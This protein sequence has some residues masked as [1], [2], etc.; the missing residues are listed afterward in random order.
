MGNAEVKSFASGAEDNTHY[1]SQFMNLEVLSHGQFL[2][3]RWV[4]F[5][6][7]KN[8][9]YQN[10]FDW[11]NVQKV[12]HPE[13]I[14]ENIRLQE[15]K[16]SLLVGRLPPMISPDLLNPSFF[17]DVQL[18]FSPSDVVDFK[19]LQNKKFLILYKFFYTLQKLRKQDQNPISSIQSTF[20]GG[21]P[22]AAEVG[23]RSGVHLLISLLREAAK[24]NQQLSDDTLNFLLELFIDVK[25]LSLWGTQQIDI[26]LDKSLHTVADYLEELISSEKTS[27][28][29]KRKALKVLFSLGLLRGSLPNLLSVV[30]LL[31]KYNLDVDLTRELKLLQLEKPNTQ[32]NFEKKLKAY[33]KIFFT[34][35]AGDAQAEKSPYVSMT[36]D[37]KYIYLH[38]ELE[39]LM[40]IGTGFGY[41]MF[42]KVYKHLK[43]YRTKEKGT[44]AFVLGKLYYRSGRIAPAPLIELDP[45][46]LEET[47]IPVHYDTLAPNSIFGELTNPEIEFPIQ[48]NS[49]Q[50][51]RG[52]LD[53]K[54]PEQKKLPSAKSVGAG[55][56]NANA[57]QNR[58]AAQQKRD[59]RLMRPAQRSPMFTDGRYI[60]IVSQWTVDSRAGRSGGGDSDDEDEGENVETKQARY[61][62]DI[63]DPVLDFEHVRAVELFDPNLIESKESNKT[64]QK[65]ALTAKALDQAIFTTNGSEL[66]VG[67]P[68]GTDDS[69][70][71]RYKFFSLTDGKLR[72][73]NP[74]KDA[75]HFYNVCYDSYNNVVFSLNDNKKTFDTISCLNNASVAEPVSF[76]EE[77]DLF[78]PFENRQIIELASE[79]VGLADQSD[80]MHKKEKE[81]KKKEEMQL[82]MSVGF[83]DDTSNYKANDI[84]F[85]NAEN[86]VN[87]STATQLF[88]LANIA[89]LA[90][91]YANLNQQGT[92]DVAN[93]IRKPY[94]V[95]LIGK[96]FRLLEEFIETYSHNF[97]EASE[98]QITDEFMFDQCS[99][100]CTLRI[101]KYNLAALENYSESLKNIGLKVLNDDFPVKLQKFIWRIFEMKPSENPDYDDIRK[102]LYKEALGIL[103]YALSIIYPD[104]SSVLSL[105]KTHLK[106]LSN[107]LNRDI[108]N[109]ILF[110]LKSKDHIVKL[111]AQILESPEY[112]SLFIKE[113]KDLVGQ[114][115]SW[116]VSQFCQYLKSCQEWE[117]LPTYESTELITTSMSFAI[118]FQKEI[119]FQLGVKIQDKSLEHTAIH[120]SSS[121]LTEVLCKNGILINFE[122][123][124][125]LSRLGQKI[126]DYFE[127]VEKSGKL[128]EEDSEKKIPTALLKYK[129]KLK[130]KKNKDELILEAYMDTWE[131]ICNVYVEKVY[132]SQILTYQL[133]ALSLLSSN[134]L[135]ASKT[136]KSISGFLT[137]LN[138]L[139]DT[140]KKYDQ[141][142]KEALATST[143]ERQLVFES[144]HPPPKDSSKKEKV[145]IPGAK[146]LKVVFDSQCELR[147]HHDWLQFFKDEQCRQLITQRMDRAGTWPKTELIIKGDFFWYNFQKNNF[148]DSQNWGY[149][150]TVSAS[151]KE[152]LEGD[153]L[154][155]LHR[156]T[157]WLAG[158]C[159]GQLING[160]A[161]QQAMLQ[162]EEQKYNSLLNS[163]LFSGG[164]EKC[165]FSGGKEGVWAQ[166]GDVINEFQAGH[167]SEYL[168]GEIS[169]AEKAEEE[170]LKDIIYAGRDEQ[171]DKTIEFIQKLFSKEA[172]WAN[173]GGENGSKCVRAAYAVIIKHSGLTNDLKE[174]MIEVE[175]GIDEKSKISPN[176]KNL[177]KKWGAASRMRSWLV[178]R[179][180]D[181]DDREEK[182]K[183]MAQAT[184]KQTAKTAMPKK[185]TFT[186]RKAARGRKA[187]EKSKEAQKEEA[188][189]EVVQM[190]E[191]KDEDPITQGGMQ[192]RDTEEIIQRMIDQIVKKAEFLC[193]LIPSK[194]WSGDR[195]EKREKQLLFRT[196]SKKDEEVNKEEEW[197]RRLTQ[198]KS[199]RQAKQVY[200][201]LEDESQEIHASLNTSVILCLQ[202]AVSIKRLRKQVESAYL[203]AI[204]RTIGL[205]ALTSILT[206]VK[207]SLFKQ[208]VVGWLCT[209]LRGTENK[210]YHFTDNLQGCG[211]YLESTVN[212]AFKN[213][214]IAIIKSMSKSDQPEEVNCMLEALKWKYHGDDHVFL[215]EID[216]FGILRGQEDKQLLR[217]AWGQSTDPKF[218]GRVEAKLV[219]NL[220]TLFETVLILCV[221]KL[222]WTAADQ[223]P[224]PK[225]DKLPSL[226][227]HVSAIDEYSVEI[228]IKQAF[229]VLFAELEEADNN[230]AKY[231]GINWRIYNRVKAVSEYQQAKAE[232]RSKQT[233]KKKSG[234]AR[235]SRRARRYND[236]EDDDY[237]D[238]GYEEDYGGMG[239]LPPASQNT[240]AEPKKKQKET[241]SDEELD[242]EEEQ[243][244]KEMQEEEKSGIEPEEESKTG[245]KSGKKEEESKEKDKPS[246]EQ[247]DDDE[248]RAARKQR[249]RLLNHLIENEK[250]ILKEMQQRLY[251]PDF[252]YRLLALIYKCVTMGSDNVSV[253]IGNPKY[254]ATLFSLIKHSPSS[255]QILITKT[256]QALFQT[257]PHELFID[258]IADLQKKGETEDGYISLKEKE[259][260]SSKV[261]K[262]FLNLLIDV[263][264]K[265]YVHAHESQ[266]SFSVSCETTGLI[267][268]L[269][270][271]PN[272]GRYVESW[273]TESIKSS[274]PLLKQ[275]AFAILGGD[276]NGLRIGGKIAIS[277][278]NRDEI[279]ADNILLK[280]DLPSNPDYAT[281]VGF[282]VEYAE[283]INEE[284]AKK[285]EKAKPA[286]KEK[287]KIRMDIGSAYSNLNPL[288]LIHSTISKEIP[289]FST[290]ELAT[291][292]R[293]NCVSKDTAPFEPESYE[294]NKNAS[295]LMPVYKWATGEDIPKD[296]NNL[297]LRTLA[298]KSLDAFSKSQENT[299]LLTSQHQ[300]LVASILNLATQSVVSS[301]LMNLELTEEKLFR[302]LQQSC[303]KGVTL[304]ELPPL[305]VTMKNKEIEILL[306]KDLSAARF[307][308]QAGFNIQSIKKYHEM[309]QIENP[310]EFIKRKD[311]AEYLADKAVLLDGQYVQKYPEIILNAQM[312]I[313][314]N[315]DLQKFAD[316]YDQVFSQSTKKNEE[317]KQQEEDRIMFSKEEALPTK[318][319]IKLPKCIVLVSDR[320]FYALNK[321]FIQ[322]KNK[323]FKEV[324]ENKDLLTELVEYGF[325]KDV[326]EKYLQENP[327]SAFDIVVNDIVKIIEQE[328]V[329]K[330]GQKKG[331][332]GPQGGSGRGVQLLNSMVAFQ[333]GQI[334]GGGF[335]QEFA[336]PSPFGG[337]LS[338]AV[339][340][341]SK[342][343]VD[344]DDEESKEGPVKKPEDPETEMEK[345][346]AK[347]M[348]MLTGELDD[349]ANPALKKI[350]EQQREQESGP[351]IGSGNV[352][353]LDE[354]TKG[355]GKS[356]AKSKETQ[357]AEA[358]EQVIFESEEE[359]EL[360]GPQDDIDIEKEDANP[361]FKCQGEKELQNVSES[362]N[363]RYDELLAFESMNQIGKIILFKQL[364]YSL[365]IFYARRILLNLIEKWSDDKPIFFITDSKYHLKFITFLKL[366]CNEA[367][368]SSG[369]FCNNTLIL[370]VRKILE[371]LFTKEANNAEISNFINVLFTESVTK[372]LEELE[373]S[374]LLKP[375]AKSK[376][377]QPQ[378]GKKSQ[379]KKGSTRR[380]YTG[381]E[382]LEF[383][384]DRP[385]L[386]HSLLIAHI[387]LNSDKEHASK[388][389][390]RFDVLFQ[391]FGIIPIIRNNRSLLW[392]A[393]IFALNMIDKFLNN[394]SL[395]DLKAPTNDP[396]LLLYHPHVVSLHEFFFKLK[397]REK[398]DSY[399]RRTQIISEILI[400][401]NRFRAVIGKS[402]PD[403]ILPIGAAGGKIDVIKYKN[404]ENLADVVDIMQ[405]YPEHR[406][407]VAATWLQVSSDLIKNEQKVIDGDH[408]YYKNLHSYKI[409]VPHAS[410]VTVKFSED[411]QTDTG[412]S[413]M[414]SSDPN[415]ELS[416]E[417][418]SGNIAKKSLTYSAGTFYLHFPTKGADVVAFGQNDTHN[419][420]HD[421]STTGPLCLEEFN[422]W[423]TQFIDGSDTH[424]WILN[425]Q[426]E[427]W[428]C[429]T[430][431]HTAL[432]GSASS[433]VF[434]Q[435]KTK[436]R[437]K[438]F[439]CGSNHSVFV[440]ESNQV[441]GVGNNQDGKLG[442]Q[443]NQGG[444]N[445]T[446]I[447]IGK[448][449][450][451][452]LS[453]GVNHTIMCT[454]DGQLFGAGSNEFGQLGL[455]DE[456]GNK[457]HSIN[458]FRHVTI[459]DA[460]VIKVSAG[461]GFSLILVRQRGKNIV[462]AAGDKTNGKLGLGDEST[463]ATIFTAIPALENANIVSIH[464]KRKHSVAV[465]HS[466]KVYSWGINDQGQLGHGDFESRSA[467]KLI[468]FFKDMKVI[469]AGVGAASTFIV[470]ASK[471]GEDTKIFAFGNNSH[472][473][474]AIKGKEKIN[475][476]TPIEFFEDKRPAKVYCGTN[477]TFVIT[478]PM[479]I[480]KIRDT[481]YF[482]CN[483]TGSKTITG[484]MLVDVLDGNKTYSAIEFE[485]AGLKSPLSIFVR[486]AIMS[487][488]VHWPNY[489]TFKADEYFEDVKPGPEVDFKLTC[490]VTGKPITGVCYVN[491]H[492]YP[493]EPQEYLCQGAAFAIP[494]N[495]VSPTLYY[496]ITRPLK[497]GKTLPVVPKSQFF[498]QSETYGYN[499][500]ITPHYNEKG[501]DYMMSK[502]SESFEAFSSDMKNLKPEV[503]EQLV[504][505]INYLTQKL[506]K[507]V[508]ELSENI[509]FPK[510][511]VSLRNA[512]EKASND[513][514]KKRFLI[515]K[516]FN[517]KFKS[518]LP[519]IDFSAKKDAT[520]LRNIY[521]NASVYIFWDVKSELFEKLLA[522]D[523][524]PS[525]NMKVK[526]NRMKASKF[527]GKGKPDHTG[528]FTVFGQI[529][530]YFKTAGFHS[531]K[532]A[533]DQNPFNVGFIGEASIDAGGPY[534]EAVSQMCT[535]LQSGALPLLIP[536]P[537][538]K[539]DSG[540]FREKWVLN[541]SANSLIHTKMYEFL[542]ALMGC[543]IRSKNFLNLDL[544]SMVWKLLVDVSVNRKDLEHIDRYLIQCLDDVIN[545]HKKGVDENSFSEIIQEKFVTT[546]SDGS[547]VELIPG[548]AKTIVT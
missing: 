329:A 335:N 496:R 83:H 127:K 294:L 29:S 99:F 503:D 481:H 207:S 395:I 281:I 430:G 227:R 321:E 112:S 428:S 295:V 101:M 263:R 319:S 311:L 441:Y 347:K 98:E 146:E 85:E 91:G 499:I 196:A 186:K 40:K 506:E 547:E 303:E 125:T 375:I 12:A 486:E 397:Q 522:H 163:K 457:M 359:G 429:G 431:S 216:L 413:L 132:F 159:A 528:E 315:Y 382:I 90:E 326:V 97:F 400:N 500:T 214:I 527:I 33:T 209:S 72:A 402:H 309:L 266:G 494:E 42:G 190:E 385:S 142:T 440:T 448:K 212:T 472:S 412:D 18:P 204:C 435:V 202:S 470:A 252:L 55:E 154:T 355:D 424:T 185:S 485:K 545:I 63:Y 393:Q 388:R 187:Q 94:S 449:V 11:S 348:K 161:L 502:Y 162:D 492:L 258:S 175:L 115:V 296:T 65:A 316:Y 31:R 357:G 273:L 365:A 451:K 379:K 73:V 46:T 167:L 172:L 254:I 523:A 437:V 307:S 334:G 24:N 405:T 174:A 381:K 433:K 107:P 286:E 268:H 474:L 459:K 262:Y 194:H 322:Q 76:P 118:E 100:L 59:L 153:W 277:T 344:G 184:Q 169:E 239:G 320:T 261:L 341:P 9:E 444:A 6:V 135:I 298:I 251:N 221:G 236:Y 171:M 490:S 505:M 211:H 372:P 264:R 160:S 114:V 178:E 299:F 39:G 482:P 278:N 137:S 52:L 512:I 56:G 531:F 53:Q 282:T 38:S 301:Q 102:A 43:D 466:G 463:N 93:N 106:D 465:S 360:L 423:N 439:S 473:R 356:P 238:D 149:K 418:V 32:F 141:E 224:Q 537:N 403:A 80:D 70:E 195:T 300:D 242:P 200:K 396:N 432:S 2:A 338:K 442:L 111:V 291:V 369:T 247:E 36:T 279:F 504:D 468:E 306:G 476:P 62:V 88:I 79:E 539:N 310:E 456:T 518:L 543:S 58:S 462:Q 205:N 164:M 546:L 491:L 317:A 226:E 166:L 139:Y 155:S 284:E 34:S 253:V 271:N 116:E 455:N 339:T 215:A 399:S 422:C 78:V 312:V 328:E 374:Y 15:N 447:D 354:E 8:K 351:V 427:L 267:R 1:L 47:G 22:K 443:W 228:L 182:L 330:K 390:H 377:E 453:C 234:E 538:Q 193:Q 407:L 534:R 280:Q 156:S 391:L 398:Q 4:A 349:E 332:G 150:F 342:G 542:G 198:W 120:Q 77:S 133:N 69:S 217:K 21:L 189:E 138:A 289:N 458:T 467:P 229:Q 421:N 48:S 123:Q 173:L 220:I 446:L 408:F 477:H 314:S 199:V 305:C 450:I 389:M 243:F 203:R 191:H 170:F 225:K 452:D 275:T 10:Y 425:K 108:T 530:Q 367:M 415:G 14:E 248:D 218:P 345:E 230:Y 401:L 260:E 510:E 434:T 244:L 325:P 368:L 145:S 147:Q 383:Q 183:Q 350:K 250:R 438:L 144:A 526:V 30:A 343:A 533:K 66:L 3:D 308:I 152:T 219:K 501:H 113:I 110:W 287:W 96:V 483:L 376:A 213:V 471:T 508:F 51:S 119:Q 292:N 363:R 495:Q 223:K 20:K 89:R 26:V 17:D 535:E 37:G 180:K 410:E 511:E 92:S 409:T 509:T 285:R 130:K 521:S 28:I 7:E 293:F 5:N 484:P 105:L 237:Y 288:V 406:S 520:R 81:E 544:P 516:A 346:K 246:E 136:L 245:S 71:T 64:R 45:D 168:V 454:V 74:V 323:E 104:I 201:S 257:L 35:A 370:N 176:I 414:F 364:N 540:Q 16:E 57:N 122:L 352:P 529:Y 313:T 49:E 517:T 392:G 148:S 256:L 361:C 272:W 331:K 445:P 498:P 19:D 366:V 386:E 25:P 290:V 507:D 60:Y 67:C 548:G 208:D 513:F 411:C 128:E 241:Y 525:S 358:E 240:N 126:Q 232:K 44:L 61:G 333:Q 54:S 269:L 420:H 480:Q 373:K 103:Q 206:G 75:S 436:D 41:T 134:F 318:E 86:A 479:Q 487:R 380:V 274:D 270:A 13:Q 222:N 340:K 324:F 337:Q 353:Q 27:P 384:I 233:D 188:K 416:A 426:G 461:L 109:A 131:Q 179:R 157:C 336:Q 95:H 541:P 129:N 124:A 475:K 304:S 259:D 249:R 493:N 265:I 464:T 469:S 488:E 489:S 524:K 197:K 151:F 394:L 283:K 82:L 417:K 165:Y 23:I 50:E 255:H 276:L 460:K 84:K 87:K 210:L 297:Y 532:V 327:S 514:L 121:D 158:K 497:K 371:S 419:Y 177:V 515:L 362:R 117:K 519:Y 387:F 302:L 378:Q 235:S 140:R 181:I 478:D 231:S 143:M 68:P 536:S 192:V 404:I